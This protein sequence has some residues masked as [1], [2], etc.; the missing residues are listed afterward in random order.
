MP[1]SK[2]LVTAV[3]R[4]VRTGC[5]G[6]QI[7]S[8]NP[9]AWAA[10]PLETET[11]AL[12]RRAREKAGL[13][14]LAVHLPYLPNL[15]SL[16]SENYEKSVQVLT[17][18]LIR[19]DSLGAEFLVAH[20]GYASQGQS[21]ETAVQRIALAVVKAFSNIKEPLYVTFL[22]ENMSGQRGEM[23][24][25]FE[26]LARIIEAVENQGGRGIPI[27]VCLDTAH[28]WGAG[29]D[30]ARPKGQDGTL[31]EFDRILGLGR[32]R[33]FHLNDS[34]VERGSRRDRHGAPGRGRIG[35]RGLARLVRHPDLDHLAGL[36]E[37]PRMSEEEDLI[38]M[39]RV[40]SW[41]RYRRPQKGGRKG[42]K[43]A[44]DS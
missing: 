27:G 11:V 17:E 29:Y 41:R 12:F 26:E 18:Q 38:N 9:R 16:P 35:S 3:E 13:F 37:T 28:A 25:D 31:E 44:L 6:F 19:A 42:V 34:L 40:M 24:A 15:A 4:A 43:S 36:M 10:K 21:R 32:L 30:L 7:F 22:L 2:G 39:A 5:E 20:P 14:P 1:I 23:G 33:L 8:S